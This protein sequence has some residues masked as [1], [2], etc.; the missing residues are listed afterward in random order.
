MKPIS[1][2]TFIRDN[3]EG[4]FCL[5]ESMA[6]VLPFVTDMHILD[7]GS[8][9]GTLQ[10][11]QAIAEVNPKIHIH[12]GRW[13]VV[14]AK[15]FADAANDAILLCQ[16]DVVWFWQADEIPHQNVLKMLPEYINTHDNLVFWR[17]QLRDNF[18]AMKW[19]PHPVHR[20]GTKRDLLLVGDGMNTKNVF[21]YDVIGDYNQGWFTKWGTMNE[22]DIPVEQ[23]VLDVSLVG[24]FRENIIGRR[25]LHAPMWHETDHI[26]GK[27][28]D[29]WYK[30]AVANDA[31]TTQTTPFDLPEIMRWHVG[32][33]KYAI[34]PQL[35]DALKADSTE[36]IIGLL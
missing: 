21:G 4:A 26:E 22:L 5:Y 8:T 1:G 9:D 14:D 27:K 17:Y 3:E 25:K 30:D 34:R 16:N 36:E 28:P 20:I 32:R 13:S 2:A 31:W 11:L 24:A 29:Q 19:F 7:V 10:W 12:Q 18:Q 6:S 15:A 35:I 23:M 33:V